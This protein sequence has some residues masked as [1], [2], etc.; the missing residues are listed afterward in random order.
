M[1]DYAALIVSFAKIGMLTFGG[2]YAIM[3]VAERELVKRRG[4]TTQEE[5]ADYYTIAMVTPGIIGINLSTFIGFSRKGIPGGI[6]ATL[7]F[8]LLPVTAVTA[9]ALSIDNFVR[10]EIVRHAVAGIRIAAC[11]LIFA[12]V[13]K[14]V[15]TQVSDWK[16]AVIAVLCL[17]WQLV[18]RAD[19]AVLVIAAGAAGFLLY[20][21]R[22]K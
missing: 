10:F 14:L 22:K 18:F 12:A 21:P 7:S 5:I 9:I 17:V 2:G 8:M 1:K 11:A 19:P 20:T 4:W 3:P 6:L 15:K 16:Q 13:L